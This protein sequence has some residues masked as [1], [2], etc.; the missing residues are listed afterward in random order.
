MNP[1]DIIRKK[2]IGVVI[3]S[4]AMATTTVLAG[5]SQEALVGEVEPTGSEDHGSAQQDAAA[6]QEQ[7]EHEVEA[8]VVRVVDGDTIVVEP[9][10]QLPANTS[11]DDGHSVRVLGIDTPEMDW[12][13]G[14]HQC[15]AAEATQLMESMVTEGDTVTLVYDEEADQFDRFD[16]SLAYVESAGVDTGAIIVAEGY[17]AAWYPSS[18]PQSQRHDQYLDAQR[19]AEQ[20]GSGAWADCESMGR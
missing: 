7:N 8:P 6:D 10:A 18:A 17:G 13:D 3:V 19:A 5:C 16:R 1:I 4:A 12:D 20:N 14:D 15:G 11:S 9:S 2:L